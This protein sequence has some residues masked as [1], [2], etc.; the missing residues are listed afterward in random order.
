[1]STFKPATSPKRTANL[2]TLL[3]HE[4]V[5][6][7][8]SCF[9]QGSRKINKR[10]PLPEVSHWKI[11]IDENFDPNPLTSTGL[12]SLVITRSPGQNDSG[13]LEFNFR[14]ERCL[15]LKEPESSAT[16]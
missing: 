9:T 15:Y 4:P 14:D 11:R 2:I 12:M 5:N 10:T 6:R 16:G 7:T 8:A 1:L 13:I 3:P